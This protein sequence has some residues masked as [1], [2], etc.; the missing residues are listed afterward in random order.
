M[1]FAD[2]KQAGKKLAEKLAAYKGKDTVVLALP[3]GG[4]VLG[5]EVAG[6]LKAPLSLVLVRKI[7]HPNHPEYAVGAVVE[8]EKPVYK[9]SEIENLDE[10]WRQKAE[11]SA[12]RLIENRRNL[13]YDEDIPPP[14]ISG[15]TVIIVD[16]GI[17]TGMT[18]QA[19]ILA[20]RS[21]GA[22]RI[23]VAVP[24]AAADALTRI[25]KLA[26]EIIVLDDP[27]EFLGAVGAH[28]QQFEQVN[29]EEVR[30]LLREASHELHQAVA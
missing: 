12:R 16:D 18:M 5:V 25:E 19:S 17:A 13:Y 15:S 29:D 3:R 23:V 10:E 8:D 4:V 26:D 27:A 22:K 7:G 1:I 2:R 14:A 28:Y 9:K 21:K 24:V 20:I 30:E 6:R 11:A